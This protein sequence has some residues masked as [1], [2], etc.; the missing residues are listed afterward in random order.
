M[1]NDGFANIYTN[2]QLRAVAD[3][4][5]IALV[6]LSLTLLANTMRDILERSGKPTR[7]RRKPAAARVDPG[8]VAAIAHPDDERSAERLGEVLLRGQRPLGRIRPARQLGEGGRARR[9]ADACAAA[10]CTG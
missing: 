9:V 7:K 4:L 2:A 3:A 6:C 1:L 8:K 10:R 5:V